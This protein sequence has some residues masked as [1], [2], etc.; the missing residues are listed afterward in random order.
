MIDLLMPVLLPLGVAILCAALGLWSGR[1]S[2]VALVLGAL[3]NLAGAFLA[4][5]ASPARLELPL[6]GFGMSLALRLGYDTGLVL[7]SAA[8]VLF[9]LASIPAAMA[10]QH[11]RRPWAVV[12]AALVGVAALNGVILADD[13]FTLVVAWGALLPVLFLALVA[14]GGEHAAG[15]ALAGL[16]A[17]DLCLVA[18]A[19]FL[20]LT[21][22]G[23]GGL[24]AVAL[25]GL[26]FALLGV[27]ALGRLGAFPFQGWVADAAVE[28]SS[29]VS[30]LLVSLVARLAGVS[31]LVTL[32]SPSTAPGW[33]RLALAVAGGLTLAAGGLRAAMAEDARRAAAS[34]GIALSGVTLLAA[35]LAGPVAA[36]LAG[37]VAAAAG[38][39]LSLLAGSK[40]L[41]SPHAALAAAVRRTPVLSGLARAA[42]ADPAA[43]ARGAVT[44]AATLLFA[45]ERLVN[46]FFD[47][48][49]V[50][51]ARAAARLAVRGDGGDHARYVIWSLLGLALVILVFAGGF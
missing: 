21:P 25:P 4:V 2:G 39:A 18:A 11:A 41:A 46:A 16:G 22:A 12:V 3:T 43:L 8:A 28:S 50:A 45:V 20:E 47:W 44:V 40:P 1:R 37:L 24:G 36:L 14:E 30:A 29:P 38:A 33:G 17:A 19:G 31:V 23:E 9:L 48:L 10:L 15:R 32:V 49:L 6:G 51:L 13:P 35:G 34:V 27:A 26:A 5:H 7:L 42:D